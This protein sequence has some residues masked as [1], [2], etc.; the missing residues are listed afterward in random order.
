MASSLLLPHQMKNPNLPRDHSTFSYNRRLKEFKKVNLKTFEP[1]IGSTVIGGIISGVSSSDGGKT[2]ELK[3]EEQLQEDKL[4]KFSLQGE[5][6][7]DSGKEAVE[8]FKKIKPATIMDTR[9]N[10]QWVENNKQWNNVIDKLEAKYRALNRKD[11]ENYIQSETKRDELRRLIALYN[12]VNKLSEIN[13]KKSKEREL[14]VHL[15]Q[16]QI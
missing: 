5:Q 7:K 6:V 14:L 16:N 2:P 1:Q 13:F 4:N 11:D 15:T 12:R 8:T 10:T 3:T 9:K